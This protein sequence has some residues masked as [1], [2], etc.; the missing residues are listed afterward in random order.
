MVR[1]TDQLF[2]RYDRQREKMLALKLAGVDP[3]KA[4]VELGQIERPWGSH[5]DAVNKS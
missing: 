2:D 5:L 3:Q 4:Q 1:H